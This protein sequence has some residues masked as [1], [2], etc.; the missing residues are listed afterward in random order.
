MKMMLI[1]ESKSFQPLLEN[2]FGPQQANVIHYMNPIKAMDN[3]EEI[4]PSVVLF[5][6]YDFPRH[7]KPFL[8]YLRTHFSRHSAVFIL[9]VDHRFPTEEASKAEYLEVN[10]IID[11]TRE[12]EETI[13]RIRAIVTRYYQSIDLRKAARYTPSE[14]DDIRFVFTN[15]YTFRI[16]TGTVVDISRGGL[17]FVPMRKEIL[18]NLDA[19]THV[20]LAS[21]RLG[22]EVYALQ[23][24]VMRVG[25]AISF[26]FTDLPLETEE[27]I[28]RFLDRIADHENAVLV[29][30]SDES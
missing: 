18:T 19:H 22:P 3:V 4:Q 21:L 29:S 25:E 24:R 6:A 7:W 27:R 12:E 23:L 2:I 28:T 20:S 9:L 30:S 14:R 10:A 16:C 26:A 8:V 13:G 11:A 15:P 17:R 5:S 1:S